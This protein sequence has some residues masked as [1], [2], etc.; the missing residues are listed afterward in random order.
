[1]QHKRAQFSNT[2]SPMIKKK[3]PLLSKGYLQNQH[4]KQKKDV[5]SKLRKK[6]VK[7]TVNKARFFKIKYL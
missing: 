3:K 6:N 7:P 4:R 1:M 5:P 2:N